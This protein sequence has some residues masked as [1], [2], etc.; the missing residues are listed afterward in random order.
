VPTAAWPPTTDADG[1]APKKIIQL[2]TDFDSAPVASSNS[3][4]VGG[5]GA[6][7]AGIDLGWGAAVSCPDPAS[8]GGAAV[9]AAA[10]EVAG[11]GHVGGLA[12]VAA[13]PVRLAVAAAALLGASPAP[14]AQR[15]AAG[16]VRLAL[17]RGIAEAGGRASRAR[18]A[19]AAALGVRAPRLARSGAVAA[20]RAGGQHA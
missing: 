14:V 15:E 10:L 11:A 17:A 18:R 3:Y 1:E 9:A 16:V 8:G 19:V 4:R 13:V 12:R 6:H 20:T 2:A 7:D 5:S